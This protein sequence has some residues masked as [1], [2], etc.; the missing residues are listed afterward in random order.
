MN[1]SIKTMLIEALKLAKSEENKTRNTALPKEIAAVINKHF[2]SRET[3]QEVQSIVKNARPQE[4]TASNFSDWSAWGG[5]ST[6][7]K[8]KNVA[9]DSTREE[10][11]V[12]DTT[13]DDNDLDEIN[14]EELVVMT[15]QQLLDK[16]G[17][18]PKIKAFVKELGLE[19]DP[20]L[21]PKAYL[22]EFREQLVMLTDDSL[23][24]E[25]FISEEE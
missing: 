21:E 3:L 19:V 18:L 2:K 23:D 11:V 20:S 5:P 4:P 25:D 1:S 13:D 24:N 8:T 15:G 17:T 12:D 16:F 22:E 7:K 6:S 9:K 14:F 10:A